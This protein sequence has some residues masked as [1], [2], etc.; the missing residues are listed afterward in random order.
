MK[1]MC[2]ECM[3]YL[4]MNSVGVAGVEAW[5]Q[6]RDDNLGSLLVPNVMW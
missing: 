1:Q 4:V 3:T 5:R 2:A 6:R